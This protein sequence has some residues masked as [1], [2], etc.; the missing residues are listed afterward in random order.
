MKFQTHQFELGEDLFAFFAGE[1][2]QD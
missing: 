1:E 2:Q